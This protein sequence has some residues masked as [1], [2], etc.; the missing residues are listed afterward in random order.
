MWAVTAALAVM[1]AWCLLFLVPLYLVLG[2]D[3]ALAVDGSEFSTFWVGLAMVVCLAAAVLGGWLVHAWSGRL[4]GVLALVGVL[5]AAGVIDAGIHSWVR[6]HWLALE[7][8]PAFVRIGL[9]MPEPAWYDWMLPAAMAVFAWV[10]GAGRA[11]EHAAPSAAQSARRFHRR[12][13][14]VGYEDANV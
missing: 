9:L 7:A 4:S 12:D 11:T 14:M 1:V 10:A 3:T 5:L 2:S 6:D 8:V 13:T